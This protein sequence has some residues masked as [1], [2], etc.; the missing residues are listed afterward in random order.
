MWD[1]SGWCSQPWLSFTFVSILPDAA[2]QCQ[3][4]V[5]QIRMFC[6]EFRLPGWIPETEDHLQPLLLCGDSPVKSSSMTSV[7]DL[8]PS[9]PSYPNNPSQVLWLTGVLSNPVLLRG[10]RGLRC[11]L[12][13]S[14]HICTDVFCFSPSCAVTGHVTGVHMRVTWF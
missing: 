13:N 5:K 7:L 9:V 3:F 8:L 10:F 4:Q 6:P 11:C 12:T 14:F 1:M 2:S